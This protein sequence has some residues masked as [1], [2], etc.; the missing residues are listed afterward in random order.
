MIG[1]RWLFQVERR[2]CCAE[3]FAALA[4]LS[5]G[6]PALGTTVFAMARTSS[7][8]NAIGLAGALRFR[9][10]LRRAFFLEGFSM[11]AEILVAFAARTTGAAGWAPAV[12]QVVRVAPAVVLF[13]QLL[14]FALIGAAGFFFS[15]SLATLD[16]AFFLLFLAM[17]SLG[18]AKIRHLTPR[19]NADKRP[20]ADL[21]PAGYPAPAARTP[22]EAKLATRTDARVNRASH[23]RGESDMGN[24]EE[25]RKKIAVFF[26]HLKCRVV[27]RQPLSVTEASK[28]FPSFPAARRGSIDSFTWART[29]SS[30]AMSLSMVASLHVAGATGHSCR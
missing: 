4:G 13:L 10:L 6:V 16:L 23:G 9:M 3:V 17:G 19:R 5:S 27:R 28:D 7:R 11:V 1:L 24:D 30:V 20:R 12:V 2:P 8:L 14:G 25:F 29:L 22:H 15:T 18:K 21:T 26:Q